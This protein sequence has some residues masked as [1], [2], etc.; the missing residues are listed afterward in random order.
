MGNFSFQTV[1]HYLLFNFHI[2]I[3][4]CIQG[5]I[6]CVPSTSLWFIGEYSEESKSLAHQLF[7]PGDNKNG[8]KMTLYLESNWELAF[9]DFCFGRCRFP[10]GFQTKPPPATTTGNVS[11]QVYIYRSIGSKWEQGKALFTPPPS[12]FQMGCCRRY[13][14]PLS[15]SHTYIHQDF[16]TFPND[17][18]QRNVDLYLRL[19]VRQDY[20]SNYIYIYI[21]F[22]YVL[23]SVFEPIRFK[24]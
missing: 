2:H 9:Y 18:F 19:A 10:A 6:F 12:G 7:I 20:N 13:N 23:R 4:I 8:K 14:L 3:Y 5:G 17:P 15:L 1:N 16:R 11:K 24:L 22:M 21:F